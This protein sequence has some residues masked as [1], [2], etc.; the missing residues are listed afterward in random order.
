MWNIFTTTAGKHQKWLITSQS[1]SRVIVV[2]DRLIVPHHS[3]VI[4]KRQYR[5]LLAGEII[6]EVSAAGGCVRYLACVCFTAFYAVKAE[7]QRFHEQLRKPR[8]SLHISS[9]RREISAMILSVLFT[10]RRQDFTDGAVRYSVRVMRACMR[11][12]VVAPLI[13]APVNEVHF[14]IS[15]QEWL[16]PRFRARARHAPR[17]SHFSSF[18][19]LRHVNFAIN[20]IHYYSSLRTF[21]RCARN[22]RQ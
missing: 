11:T 6:T 12:C 21:T 9:A 7:L 8:I 18:T 17:A 1:Y 19:L 20:K 14:R 2:A 4:R 16:F 15:S 13:V 3:Y 22:V 5:V 10:A